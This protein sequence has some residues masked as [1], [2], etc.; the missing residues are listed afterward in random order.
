MFFKKKTEPE[1]A[2]NPIDHIRAAVDKAA[3]YM[4]SH[5][6]AST[7]QEIAERYERKAAVSCESR[8]PWTNGIPPL[9]V[10]HQDKPKYLGLADIIRGGKRKSK[11]EQIAA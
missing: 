5:Q 6:V 9:Q 3:G 1:P 8:Q 4:P 2:F 10:F 7:L 11:V